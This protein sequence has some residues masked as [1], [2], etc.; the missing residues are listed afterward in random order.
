[1]ENLN[2]DFLL[3]YINAKSELDT[4]VFG[5]GV[6]DDP[7]YFQK[8]E[9]V[10]LKTQAELSLF[11]KSWN[12]KLGLAVN[13]H[14]RYYKNPKDPEHPFDFERGSYYGELMKLDWQHHLKLHKTNFL[15]FG[16]EFERE[17]GKSRYYSESIW[18]HDKS[19]FTKKTA[20][21]KGYYVQDEVKLLDRLFG[22]IGIRIDDH[23]RFG[24]ETTYRIAPAYLIK[25]TDTKIRGTIGTGFKAPSLYQLFAPATLW[26]P[27]GNKNLK[28]EKSKG[29]DVGVEQSLFGGK[30]VLGATVFRND[31]KDLIQF[32]S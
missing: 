7:N 28:P 29:W 15:T 6:V 12:Q 10:L 21:I 16:F 20:N 1:M 32:E 9:Q 23:S 30:V 25:E 4:W 31:F 11:D 18:G 17:E 27:I 3:R 14:D 2:I 24:T 19:V 8:S 13:D 26:G 22:T 5:V